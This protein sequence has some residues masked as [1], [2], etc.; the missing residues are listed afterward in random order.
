MGRREAK[1]IREIT[2]TKTGRR[3][4]RKGIREIGKTKKR[5]RG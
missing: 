2:K 1:E 3:V 5:E 4:R